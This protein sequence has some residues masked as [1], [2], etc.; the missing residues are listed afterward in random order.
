MENTSKDPKNFRS[1][2]FSWAELSNVKKLS[3]V[4]VQDGQNDVEYQIELLDEPTKPYLQGEAH[5]KSRWY[6][7]TR[8]DAPTFDKEWSETKTI[9]EINRRLHEGFNIR[10]VD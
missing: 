4:L 7:H 3:L 2:H 6:R 1:S 9:K 8:N 5:L 10:F